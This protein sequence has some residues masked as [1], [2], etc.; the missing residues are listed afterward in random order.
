MGSLAVLGSSKALALSLLLLLALLAVGYQEEGGV[1]HEGARFAI[2]LH[3]DDG[4]CISSSGASPCS[5]IATSNGTFLAP[6]DY[7]ATPSGREQPF[8]N[9]PVMAHNFH[10]VH[11]L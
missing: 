4:G 7:T 11:I 10:L 1:E 5:N 9:D 6:H 3:P 2:I 8:A